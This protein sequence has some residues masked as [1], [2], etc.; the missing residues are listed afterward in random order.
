MPVGV[1]EKR[2]QHQ[3]LHV[4]EDAEGESGGK[5]TLAQ[6]AGAM[7]ARVVAGD[8]DKGTRHRDRVIRA[9]DPMDGLEMG[10]VD[11]KQQAA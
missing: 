9:D 5:T 1:E 8:G 7:P 11:E 10:D 2:K 4:S 3:H 6:R